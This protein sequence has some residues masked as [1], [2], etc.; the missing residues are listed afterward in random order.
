M[1]RTEAIAII[2]AKLS[3]LDDER[4]MTVA[5]IV[6][7]MAQPD[8]LPRELTPRELALIEQSKEDFKAGRTYSLDE[9]RA[10]TD[11]FLAPL[12]VPQSTA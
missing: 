11:A 5:D 3:S 10:M 6:Q 9:A 4:V 1:T 2:T 12:G 7:D 8:D